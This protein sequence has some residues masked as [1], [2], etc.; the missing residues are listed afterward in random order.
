M[1]IPREP[2]KKR[3]RYVV[4]SI[5]IGAVALT[6]LALSR[7][8]PAA[9][10]V[11]RAAV[12]VDTVR[13]GEMVRQVRGPGTL[14]PEEIRW[15]S[16]IAAGRV[17]SKLVLPGTQ[18]EDTTVLLILSNPDVQLQALEAE[19]QL[20]QSEAELVNL[21]ATLETQRLNQEATVASVRAQY[22]E[23]KR[24]VE[25]SQ[26]LAER[27]LIAEMELSRTKDTAEELAKRLEVE[28]RRLEILSQQV[29]AQLAVQ[30]AQVERNR[31]IVAFQRDQIASMTVRAGAQGVLQELRLEV[32]QWANSGTV[33]ARVVQPG[34]LKAVLRIPETQAK[35]VV[36]GQKASID[37]R[38]GIIPGRV[39]RID[40]AVQTGTVG[41]DVALEGDLPAGARPDLS[42]DGTIEIERLDNVLYVGRPAYGQANSRI[43]L[44]KL[45]E[46]GRAAER[47]YVTLGRSSVNTIEIVDGIQAGDVVILS[48]MSQWDAFDRVRL[49]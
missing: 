44:F 46:G 7:L 15:I 5:G 12:W 36:L 19:R 4:I 1:D 28:L 3:G 2:R 32:G 17:E 18:V 9:P 40:P 45:V 48:D 25:A 23:A 11:D 8:K 21:R 14:V 35:D 31:A 6:T 38:N 10:S 29:E 22:N 27:G 47:V 49:R 30:Q 24:Q 42:V 39:I 41:V 33:L 43:G 37:T 34:R 13:M 26:E 16:A 20:T